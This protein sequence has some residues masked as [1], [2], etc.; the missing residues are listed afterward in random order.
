M[1]VYVCI[2]R[3]FSDYDKVFIKINIYICILFYIY[4]IFIFLIEQVCVVQQ[5]WVDNGDIG[6]WIGCYFK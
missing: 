1:Y 3:N 6:Y 2:Y 5:Y 4:Y